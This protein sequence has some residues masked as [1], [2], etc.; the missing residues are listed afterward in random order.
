M[1]KRSFVL[2]ERRKSM[3]E[4]P[5][6]MVSRGFVFS[7]LKKGGEWTVESLIK[8]K[9]RLTKKGEIW[10]IDDASVTKAV[11]SMLHFWKT[12]KQR[13]DGTLEIC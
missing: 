11:D 10:N 8:E 1:Y 6:V 7:T 2:I 9:D 12:I 13:K 4:D 3:Q 5:K